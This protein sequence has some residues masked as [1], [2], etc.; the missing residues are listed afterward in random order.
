VSA[1]PP[2]LFGTWALRRRVV[3]R[4]TGRFGRVTG[5]LDLSPVGPRMHWLETGRLEWDGAVYPVTRELYLTLD[6]DGWQMRFA[7]GRLFHPWRPGA[8]VEHH[9]RA[10]LYRGLIDVDAQCA[11][12]RVL[13]DVTGPAKDQRIVTRCL[14]SVT[15]AGRGPAAGAPSGVIRNGTP[16]SWRAR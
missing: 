4:R 3:D 16:Q 1:A 12:L 6:E 5:R 9:C 7:D 10:D 15:R 13:W 11:R 14:R 2:D 8:V